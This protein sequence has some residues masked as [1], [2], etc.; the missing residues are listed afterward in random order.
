MTKESPPLSPSISFNS[1]ISQI[2]SLNS[3]EE[4]KYQ[5]NG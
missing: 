4:N 1:P 3:L 5:M 2:V